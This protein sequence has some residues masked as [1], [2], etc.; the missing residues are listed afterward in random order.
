MKK[1]FYAF[2]ISFILISCNEKKENKII[3][4]ETVNEIQNKELKTVS[5]DACKLCK[6]FLYSYQKNYDTIYAKDFINYEG[7]FSINF[8]NLEYFINKSQL[9]KYFT[10][11]YITDFR[12]RIIEINQKLKETP[13][14][15]GTIEGLESDVFL[16]TQDIEDCLNQIMNKKIICNQ[17]DENKLEIDFGNSHILVFSIIDNRI[18]DIKVKK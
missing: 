17:I 16:H 14:N 13:Q 6:D 7:N 15:D 18:N 4:N 9:N 1:I 10:E 5:F 11:K 8:E 2:I 3:K 12:G